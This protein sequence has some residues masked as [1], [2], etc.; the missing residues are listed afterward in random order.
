MK[1]FFTP[2]CLYWGY[3]ISFGGFLATKNKVH[4]HNKSAL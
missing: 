3:L 1:A 2:R 4:H